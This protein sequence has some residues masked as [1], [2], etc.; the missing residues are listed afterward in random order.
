MDELNIFLTAHCIAIAYALFHITVYYYLYY[1]RSKSGYQFLPISY[2]YRHR[3]GSQEYVNAWPLENLGAIYC[4]SG[5]LIR[6]SCISD[7]NEAVEAMVIGQESMQIEV[8]ARGEPVAEGEEVA[9]RLPY[10]CTDCWYNG[11]IFQLRQPGE[12]PE[13][14]ALIENPIYQDGGSPYAFEVWLP[15]PKTGFKTEYQLA[16]YAAASVLDKSPPLHL[17]LYARFLQH[18]WTYLAIWL[19]SVAAPLFIY[20]TR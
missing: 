7:E 9:D 2:H 12:M 5:D 19:F 11:K 4:L 6:V 14:L 10:W 17:F 18:K 13:G 1:T 20:L 8:N 16:Y 15:G 3:D